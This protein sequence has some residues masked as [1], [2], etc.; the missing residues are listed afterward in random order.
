MVRI[1]HDDP[2]LCPALAERGP[3]GLGDE[4]SVG[5]RGVRDVEIAR[6]LPQRMVRL[7]SEAHGLGPGLRCHT[8]PDGFDLPGRVQPQ[9]T[10]PWPAVP[11]AHPGEH[12]PALQVAEVCLVERCR[13]EAD[14]HLTGLHQR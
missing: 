11:G 1:H 14:Q 4:P 13:S 3:A 8:R 10:V 9:A 7:A 12:G 6:D 2:T 5:R